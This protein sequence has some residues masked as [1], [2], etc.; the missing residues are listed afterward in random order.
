MKPIKLNIN[1]KTQKYPIVIGSNLISKI[2][3][4]T[5]DNSINFKKCLLIIDNNVP[6][7]FI[8][9]IKKSL[10]QKKIYIYFFNANENNK[11]FIIVN[12]ILEILL[13]K[14]FSRED[15]LISIGG[16]ITG[17]VTGFAASIFKRGLKFINIP[18]TLLSQVDSS[19]GGKTGINSK[20]GKN[21]IGSF[22]QPNMVISDTQ[23]LKSLSKRE[24]VCGY[25]EI[26][27]H[28]LIKNKK[29]FRF[30]DKNSKKIIQLSSPFIER[31]IY[32]SCKIKKNV[33]E[34]DEKEK[35]LRKILNFGHTFG[36]SYEASLGYNKK[37]NHG[38]AV[39]LGM[40][41]A[42]NFSLKLNILKKKDYILIINHIKKLNFP[43]SINNFFTTKDLKKILFFMLKD[44]KNKS[45]KISLVL[46]KSIGSVV[47]NKE[48]SKESLKLF[49][50]EYLRN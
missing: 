12:N 37:L 32:E 48:Y 3:K 2:S 41:T 46:L 5:K 22:Y 49:L 45:D 44:K 20:Y 13:N 10:K 39:I 17:D 26:L 19:I 16:G 31:A 33:V 43:N 36:H 24:I 38:E 47:I 40:Q 11:N 4:V 28:S 14:N 30:L 23:F 6:K 27:K 29:F 35:N 42:L 8:F 7:K 50:K 25:G 21:L 34:K 1:T 18:T 9:K 15:C